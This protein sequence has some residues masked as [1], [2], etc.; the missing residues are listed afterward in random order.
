VPS[1]SLRTSIS[2]SLTIS[3]TFIYNNYVQALDTLD[4]AQAELSTRLKAFK[5]TTADIEMYIKQERDFLLQHEV[6]ETE[7][8]TFLIDYHRLLL[9]FWTLRYDLFQLTVAWSLIH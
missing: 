6:S 9:D 4:V 2:C 3:G 7:E 1:T 5:L 8:D